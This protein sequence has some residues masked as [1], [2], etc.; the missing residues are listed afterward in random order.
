MSQV[1]DEKPN[2]RSYCILG[3]VPDKY[4][5]YTTA[6]WNCKDK[7]KL[8]ETVDDCIGWNCNDILF[9]ENITVILM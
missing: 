4:S 2:N 6:N 9:E 3:E 7:L 5:D 1:S 8:Y